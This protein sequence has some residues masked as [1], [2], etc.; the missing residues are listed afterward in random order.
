MSVICERIDDVYYV[1]RPSN[2]NIYMDWFGLHTHGE[3]HGRGTRLE[4][5]PSSAIIINAAY[6]CDEDEKQHNEIYNNP[7]Y[8]D[9]YKSLNDN[10][11]QSGVIYGDDHNIRETSLQ[12]FLEIF[13]LSNHVY[14]KLYRPSDDHFK[15]IIQ[16][17]LGGNRQCCDHSE[18][19][20]DSNI[21][22]Y[23]KKYYPEIVL[24]MKTEQF[25]AS[26]MIDEVYN[27]GIVFKQDEI[28]K[29]LQQVL[30]IARK[31]NVTFHWI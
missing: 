18:E 7:K 13:T 16:S 31:Y 22:Q 30:G 8:E 24:N 6:I 3:V 10:P 2:G 23:L 19:I 12:K 1:I 21:I 9:V 17:I 27:F 11:N 5:T 25:S 20:M 14:I 29:E 15:C 4:F 28:I 26:V